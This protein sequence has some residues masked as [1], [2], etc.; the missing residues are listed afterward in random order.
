MPL[1]IPLALLTLYIYGLYLNSKRLKIAYLQAKEKYIEAEQNLF[2][3]VEDILGVYDLNR[4]KSNKIWI[5]MPKCLIYYS[6]GKPHDIKKNVSQ[7]NTYEYWY[8][9]P[10]P[11][12]YNGEIRYKYE[13]QVEIHNSFVTGW[14]D[15]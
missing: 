2:N 15:L 8:Y 13:T 6:W 9:G 14:K 5:E 3:E 10:K 1:F 11:Y 7:A 4:L 12:K